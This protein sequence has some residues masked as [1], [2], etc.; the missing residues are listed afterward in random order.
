MCNTLSPYL[1]D[2]F[3]EYLTTFKGGSHKPS[4]AEKH[5]L[6]V[7][8]IVKYVKGPIDQSGSQVADIVQDKIKE[9][10]MPSTMRT[11]LYSFK[12]YLKFL[13]VLSSYGQIQ[14]DISKLKAVGES[15]NTWAQS[16]KKEAMKQKKIPDGE[17]FLTPDEVQSYLKSARAEEARKLIATSQGADQ[18]KHAAVR[19][20]LIFRFALSNAHRTGCVTNLLLG[21]FHSAVEKAGHMVVH[22]A[23]HKTW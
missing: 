18:K 6:Q 19:N 11:Y 12:L 22:V 5:K 10:L 8:S 2:G 15:I 7:W 14:L 3:K 1:Q 21:E 20:H 13:I 9:G 16:L 4:I 23:D 17:D